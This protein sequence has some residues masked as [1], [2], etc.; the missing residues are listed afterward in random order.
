MCVCSLHI[1]ANIASIKDIPTL[2]GSNYKEWKDQMEIVLGLADLDAALQEEKPAALTKESDD[3]AKLDMARWLR[4]NRMCLKIMQKTI[5]EVFRGTVSENTTAKEFLADIEQR[6]VRNEKAE[7]A[8]LLKK[9]CSKQYSGNGNI[10]EYILEM[11]HM[12][13]KLKAM[14]LDVSDDM[15]VVMILNSLPSKFGHFIVS[16]NCQKEKW[17]VNELISHCVQEEERL[18][19]ETME[20][21]NVATSSRKK[22]SKKRK[23]ADKDKGQKQQKADYRFGVGHMLLLQG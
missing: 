7:M 13:S 18:K 2:N 8:S 20:S 16:Y 5:P 6:F 17:T 10:R 19:T 11:T 14:K 21:A 15:L 23:V 9:F 3:N 4:S 12:V 22:G 1:S